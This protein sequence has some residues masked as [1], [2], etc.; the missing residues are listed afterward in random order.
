[1][2]KLLF[3]LILGIICLSSVFAQYEPYTQKGLPE[4]AIA[5]FGRGRIKELMYSP[6]G[7]RLAVITS[8]GVWIYDTQT[9]EELDLIAGEH[10]DRVYDAAYAPDSK[11][12]ATVGKDKTVRLWEVHTGQLLK[13]L[14]GHKDEVLSVAYS[15]DGQTLASGGSDN[16]IRIWNANT[17]Q[18][19]KTLIGHKKGVLSVAYSLDSET[20][21]SSSSDDTIR[22]WDVAKGQLKNIVQGYRALISYSPDGKTLLVVADTDSSNS[23]LIKSKDSEGKTD[24]EIIPIMTLDTIYTI[25][26][27]NA[28]TGEQINIIS[29]L[30]YV[31]CFSYSPDG[32]T[33][34]ISDGERFGLWDATTG[35]HLTTLIEDKIKAVAYSPDGK[36]IAT[37][38]GNTIQWWNAQT[39]KSIKTFPWSTYYSYAIRLS[40]DGKTIA[41]LHGNSICLCNAE[42]GKYLTTITGHKR[43]ISGFAFSPDSKT[44]ATGGGDGTARLWNANTGENIHIINFP[45]DPRNEPISI[46]PPKYSP[47]GKSL[48]IR[49]KDNTVF[50]WD[51]QLEYIIKTIPGKHYH[52]KQF[53]FSHN[54]KILATRSKTEAVHLWNTKTGQYIN[55][56]TGLV[57]F[58]T[59]SP[60]GNILATSLNNWVEL[61]SINTGENLSKLFIPNACNTK[62]MYAENGNPFTITIHQN[63]SVSLWDLTTGEHIQAFEGDMNETLA[64]LGRSFLRMANKDTLASVNNQI[65]VSPTQDTFVTVVNHN[66]VRLWNITTRKQIGKSIIPLK[67]EKS[68]TIVQYS[69]DGKTI[70]TIPVGTNQQGGT[71]RLWDVAS[72]EHLKTLKGHSNCD[73][74]S[75]AYFPDSK[76]I[77]TGHDD[78]TV[79]LWDIP[80][81]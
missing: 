49:S 65:I 74:N 61:W 3:L 34:A 28:V 25:H 76:T 22:F 6:D 19:L 67:G 45:T 36:T 32:K 38:S 80:T 27:L 60:D 46:D 10:E 18:L 23:F 47:D 43:S 50:L 63:E 52:T 1:M 8:I 12:I 68:Y 55:T 40:P 44:I 81:R 17:G 11:N 14:N 79:I 29:S 21:V 31:N 39:G 41:I 26:M 73:Y 13:T 72:G 33:I 42:S 35:K 64:S 9:G 59:F 66:P 30:N 57:H 2:K 78:G 16:T 54:G 70:A 69:P 7:T 62:I 58:I 77:A 56:L 20:I 71:V 24:T 15:P 53:V 37:V 75:V 51:M 4:G 48:A 5:R